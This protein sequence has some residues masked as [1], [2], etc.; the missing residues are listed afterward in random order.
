MAV[1]VEKTGL[2]WVKDGKIYVQDPEG[3]ARLAVITRGEGVRLWVNGTEKFDPTPVRESDEITYE[4]ET[5]EEPGRVTVM[6]AP[7]KS[8]AFLDVRLTRRTTYNLLDSE[9]QQSLSLDTNP[10]VEM[11]MPLT[12]EE[13]RTLL[14]ENGVVYGIQDAFIASLYE[15]PVE[16]RH[17]IA[18]GKAPESPVNETVELCVFQV[19]EAKPL[20]MEDGTVDYRNLQRFA[21]VE[22]GTV[23]AVK[24]PGIPGKS[25]FRVNGEEVYAPEPKIVELQAGH[26]AALSPDGMSV[27]ASA[28]GLP[29]F[30]QTATRCVVSVD[31]RLTIKGDVNLETGNINF[32]GSVHVMGSVHEAMKVEATGDIFVGGDIAGAVV[33]ARGNVIARSIIASTVR[34]GGQTIYYEKLKAPLTQL[35]QALVQAVQGVGTMVEH[36]AARNQALAPGPALLLVIEQKYRQVPSLIKE[37]VKL[38]EE[39]PQFKIE[40]DPAIIESISNAKRVFLGLGLADFNNLEKVIKIVKDLSAVQDE[41]LTLVSTGRARVV[42]QY[43]L[44]SHIEATGDVLVTGQGAYNTNI[45]SSG[46]VKIEGIFRA[47]ELAAQGNVFIGKAGS[48]IGVRTV[49]KVPWGKNIELKKAHPGVIVQI[50]K[51]VVEVSRPMRMINTS[52][53]SDGQIELN[54]ISWTPTEGDS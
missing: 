13:M 17:L 54:G 42:V 36:A 7:N 33:E 23:L 34:A 49:I 41:I 11:K 10:N 47:G 25:G 39:A 37:L 35:V 5:K 51:Q 26:G 6:I 29:V 19:E 21:S 48:D 45:L 52:I 30:R 24:K 38:M 14:R 8:K 22:P 50:G 31:P 40:L 16:G 27:I 2:A 12:E 32:R 20:I 53:N 46:K 44:N 18:E 15:S 43:T 4:T 3:K 28:E 9:P 1:E